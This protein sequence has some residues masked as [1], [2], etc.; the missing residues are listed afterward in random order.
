MKIFRF[1]KFS[2]STVIVYD[3]PNRIGLFMNIEDFYIEKIKQ[4]Y[5]E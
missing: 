1:I 3:N 4:L 5:E 2:D